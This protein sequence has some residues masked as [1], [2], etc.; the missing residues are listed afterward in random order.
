MLAW[1]W[2]VFLRLIVVST[3]V[4][5]LSPIF[6][7]LNQDVDTFPRGWE[8]PLAAAVLGLPL[9]EPH[10]EEPGHSAPTG[11]AAAPSE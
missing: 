5:V 3:L 2:F 6:C 7:V 8:I 9:P 1:S 4:W 10:A 11:A